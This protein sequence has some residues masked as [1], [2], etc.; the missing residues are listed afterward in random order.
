MRLG[1]DQDYVE[2]EAEEDEVRV[3]V[4]LSWP[5]I[6]GIVLALF[7][8]ILASLLVGMGAL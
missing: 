6:A 2:V 1:D 5:I 3:G 8:C 7:A 4:Q